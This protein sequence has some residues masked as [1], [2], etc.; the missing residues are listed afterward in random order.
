LSKIED[1]GDGFQFFQFTASL[2]VN[3]QEPA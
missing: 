2:L 3:R 1:K